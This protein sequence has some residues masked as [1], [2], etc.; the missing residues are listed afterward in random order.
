MVGKIDQL[1][2]GGKRASLFIGRTMLESL[3]EASE[4]EVWVSC[5]L[6]KGHKSKTPGADRIHLWMNCNQQEAIEVLKGLFDR[7]VID[8]ST[9]KFLTN[10][11]AL[12]FSKLLRSP[13]SCLIFES[14]SG[15]IIPRSEITTRSFDTNTY[16]VEV[17]LEERAKR[18]D[19][20][21]KIMTQYEEETPLEQKEKDW[22][23]YET[24]AEAISFIEAGLS[25]DD[26][27]NDFASYIV[28]TRGGMQSDRAYK[29]ELSKWGIE[30]FKLHLETIYNCIDLRCKDFPYPENYK[31]RGYFLVSTPK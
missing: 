3:P 31:A 12:R 5:D 19:E 26:L 8:T 24:T 11:F 28:E 27:K 30:Q 4:D 16:T 29:E 10:D 7:V 6:F 14:S 22:Q 21:S 25:R 2:Q 15:V 1:V 13:E 18:R 9:I 17:P 20:V 23:E